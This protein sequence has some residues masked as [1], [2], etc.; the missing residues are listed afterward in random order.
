M[1]PFGSTEGIALLK[2]NPEWFDPSLPRTAFQLV[3]VKF[4]YL[5]GST[6]PDDPKPTEDGSIIGVRMWESLHKSDWKAIRAVLA[7]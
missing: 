2:P 6:D 1:A 3:T 4:T 7:P 5:C